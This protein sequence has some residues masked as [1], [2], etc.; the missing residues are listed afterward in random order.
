[1]RSKILL[2]TDSTYETSVLKKIFAECDISKEFTEPDCIKIIYPYK[3][4]E[5]QK[6][7]TKLRDGDIKSFSTEKKVV[8]PDGSERWLNITAAD[9]GEGKNNNH[10]YI[11]VIRDITT[12]YIN[13]KVVRSISETNKIIS[14]CM[15]KAFPNIKDRLDYTLDKAIKLTESRY[16]YIYFYDEGK[17]EVKFHAWSDDIIK[18]KHIN[19]LIYTSLE[20]TGLLGAAAS[21]RKPVVINDFESAN[22][23]NIGNTAGHAEIKKYM[24]VPIFDDDS[25]VAV[26]GFA[27]KDSDYTENDVYITTILMSG[28]WNIYKKEKKEKEAEIFIYHD[29]LTGIYNR[30]YFEAEFA[31]RYNR[32]YDEYPIA[33]LVGDVNGLKQYNDTF[34]HIEGDRALREIAGAI[35]ECLNGGDVLA[36]IGGDEFAILVSQTNEAD[37]KKYIDLIE[38]AVNNSH[39][40]RINRSLSISFG[41]GI[42]R[43]RKEG[44]DGLYKEAEAFMYNRKYYNSRSARGNTVNVIME[45]LFAK[46]EQEKKHS[47]RVGTICE[48]I[49]TEMNL[50]KQSIDRIRVAGLLHDIGKIGIDENILKKIGKLDPKEWEIMKLHSTKGARILEN[51]MEYKDIADIVLAHHEKYDGSGYPKRLKAHDIPLE[52]RII[53]VAD[54][55]DAMTNNRTYRKKMTNEEA[56][57]ELNKCSGSH[58]DPGIVSVFFKVAGNLE[59]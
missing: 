8:K 27:N 57:K 47:E 17:K 44:I 58:F 25:I 32:D 29:Y 13:K 38:K 34:G 55:F 3:Q 59:V 21:Q 26:A 15:L 33:V 5:M 12:E 2:I 50:D 39:T 14:E 4:E 16:G 20:K 28:V 31:G 35:K 9:T 30:G 19:E 49:S 40:P 11:C 41:Y 56:L 42:Q 37:L 36:R 10:N 43:N 46:S 22:Q 23:I 6:A 53:A 48:K 1:M 18:D 51:S 52:A 7:L 45:T 54:A 24:T